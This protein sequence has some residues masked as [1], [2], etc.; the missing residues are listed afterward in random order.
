MYWTVRVA[1]AAAADTSG[2]PCASALPS[3]CALVAQAASM[4]EI[5]CAPCFAGPASAAHV[6]GRFGEGRSLCPA[7]PSRRRRR[8]RLALP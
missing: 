8:R 1:R 4:R 6:F 2:A 5:C 3:V 7:P